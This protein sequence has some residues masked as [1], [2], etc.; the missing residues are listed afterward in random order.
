[1][2]EYELIIDKALKKGLS[3]NRSIATNSEWLWQAMGFRVGREDLEGYDISSDDPLS[4]VDLHYNWPFPQFIVGEAYNILVVRNILTEEDIVYQVS[5]DYA[6]VTLIAT[7]DQLTYG[8]GSLMEVADFGEYLFMTNGVINLNWD[9][10]FAAWAIVPVSASLPQMSTICNFKGQAVGG[11]ITGVYHDCD[12]T[13][14]VWSK[15]G[16]FNF[17]PEANNEAGYRR[18]P[19][20]GEVLNVRRLGNSVIGYSS[21]GVTSLTP[22]VEP[23]VTMGFTELS[24]VGLINKGAIDGDHRRHVYVGS[25]YI[26]REITVG[27][28]TFVQGGIKELGYFRYMDELNGSEDI[29]VKYDRIKK[30]FYIGNSTHTFLLSPYGLTQVP[31]HPSALWTLSDDEE[32]PVMLPRTV[33]TLDD[34]GDAYAPYI[35]TNTFDMGYRGQKTISGLETDALIILEA[36]AAIGWMNTIAAWGWTDFV[37]INNE[38]VAAI[39]AS[40]ADFIAKIKFAYTVSAVS[41]NYIKIRYKM[42]DLRGIR[43]VYAPPLRGQ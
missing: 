41:I 42:S 9:L 18:C 3:P 14:Y 24:D 21:K 39:T 37:P 20:G 34:D 36:E 32:E 6:T 35:A 43:G 1:M 2:R 29:I 38:G 40:A 5:D 23:T 8:T 4:A 22:S 27:S 12:E 19:Y 7:I 15:I 25:D 17:T 13:F 30:D 26:L 28:G 10:T 11:N 16:E 33:D 31:Q